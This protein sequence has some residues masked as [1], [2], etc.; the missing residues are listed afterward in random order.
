MKNQKQEQVDLSET[1]KDVLK[2]GNE[3]VDLIKI[4][5]LFQSKGALYIK[6]RLPISL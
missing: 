1:N 4:G 2:T 5:K 6:E 3:V